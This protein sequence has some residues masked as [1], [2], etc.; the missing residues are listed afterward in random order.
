MSA[1]KATQKTGRQVTMAMMATPRRRQAPPDF[2]I[3]RSK[4]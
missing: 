2:R 4:R 1:D 3:W